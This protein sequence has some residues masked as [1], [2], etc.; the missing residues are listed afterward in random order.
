MNENEEKVIDVDVIKDDTKKKM[1]PK[2]KRNAIIICSIGTAILLGTIAIP[3]I[4]HFADQISPSKKTSPSF[5]WDNQ[6]PGL[7]TEN[8]I[9]RTN[10]NVFSLEK[11]GERYVV[12]GIKVS[13]ED[14]Y[15]IMPSAV[16]ISS[17]NKTY[18]I[19]NVTLKEENATNIFASSTTKIK[20][21]YFS[22]IYTNIGDSTFT[23]M[24]DLEEVKFGSGDGYQTIGSNAFSENHSLKSITFSKNLHTLGENV[25]ENDTSLEKLSFS[26]TKLQNIGEKAFKG[27]S[28]LK[29]IY[30]PSSIASI[31]SELFSGCISLT[32]INYEGSVAAWANLT[33]STTWNQNSSI[34]NVICSDGSIVQ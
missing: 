20:G 29:E 31:P 33:K 26:N 13:D 15:L 10:E 23:N 17:E 27:C 3:V 1:S 22:D 2:E 5:T 6:T 14:K 34:T 16:T 30:L 24:P 25:F 32:K 12:S 19:D 21:V 11:E 9:F 7:Y 8:G 18:N 28:S 4:G